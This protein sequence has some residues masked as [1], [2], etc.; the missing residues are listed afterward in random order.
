MQGLVRKK[1]NVS[2]TKATHIEKSKQPFLDKMGN[3]TNTD[4]A[5]KLSKKKHYS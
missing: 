3:L 5:L 2:R 4:I 1:T